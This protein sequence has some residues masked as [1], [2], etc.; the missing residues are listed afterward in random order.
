M[1]L[2]FKLQGLDARVTSG[3]KNKL[4]LPGERHWYPA[5]LL[6]GSRG[7]TWKVV[8]PVPLLAILVW[9]RSMF[10]VIITWFKLLAQVVGSRGWRC[11]GGS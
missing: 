4:G 3:G 6:P 10:K 2:G 1:G 11:S 5:D 9:P 8:T 7:R